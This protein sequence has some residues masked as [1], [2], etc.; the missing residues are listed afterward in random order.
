VTKNKSVSFLWPTVH[1][2]TK[3][4][5]STQNLNFNNHKTIYIFTQAENLPDNCDKTISLWDVFSTF[6]KANILLWLVLCVPVITQ[7]H[8]DPT[9]SFEAVE[10][11]FLYVTTDYLQPCHTEM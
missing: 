3:Q 8:W 9:L 5:T 1:G 4:L 6:T 10:P 7:C 2:H 11:D